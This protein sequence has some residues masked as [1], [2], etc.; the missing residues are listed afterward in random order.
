MRFTGRTI[1]ALVEH[2]PTD[3]EGL[4]RARDR[5]AKRDRNNRDTEE[6]DLK[7]LMGSRRGRRIVYRLLEQAGVF[8]SVFN[9]NAMQMAFS[10]GCRNYG[11]RTL[12]LL[13]THCPELYAAMLKEARDA[14]D[15]DG[16]DGHSDQ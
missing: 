15:A 7:W 16:H 11:L 13:T 2:D 9:T 10:E 1:F 12:T 6:S 4:E 8:R 3:L 14:R 5:K